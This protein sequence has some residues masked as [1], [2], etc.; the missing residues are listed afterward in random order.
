[1]GEE[2]VGIWFNGKKYYGSKELLKKLGWYDEQTVQRSVDSM[3]RSIDFMQRQQSEQQHQ[4]YSVKYTD[5]LS[6]K[7]GFEAGLLGYGSGDIYNPAYNIGVR[8]GREVRDR[9]FQ[10]RELPSDLHPRMI[11]EDPEWLRENLTRDFSQPCRTLPSDYS[12]TSL[13]RSDR[14]FS[15]FAFSSLTGGTGFV[16]TLLPLLLIGGITG[17]VDKDSYANFAFSVSAV[18]GVVGTTLGIYWGWRKK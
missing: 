4:R 1:M 11:W 15:A 2:H 5:K 14:I 18:G 3:Q 6:Y 10:P 8:E 9:Q 16:A 13:T 12:S 7:E 17:L